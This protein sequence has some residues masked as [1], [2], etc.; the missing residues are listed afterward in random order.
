MSIISTKEV[1][2][3]VHSAIDD[4]RRGEIC[5]FFHRKANDMSYYNKEQVNKQAEM[6]HDLKQQGKVEILECNNKDD[7]F[8]KGKH[9]YILVVQHQGVEVG[10]DKTGFSWD[11]R[12]FLVD[13]FIY[14]FEDK[15]NR[16]TVYK[17]VMDIQDKPISLDDIVEKIGS[18]EVVEEKVAT[19]S[20]SQLKKEKARE[21]NKRRA[22]E[23]A[24]KIKRQEKEAKYL[25]QKRKEAE[26][27]RIAVCRAKRK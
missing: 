13:G 24:D 17:Y 25:E 21:A 19:K 6:W 12:T 16:D 8:I 26:R 27:K 15:F 4:K 22:Q 10:M 3:F 2:K 1:T 7:V 14:Y 18:I 9:F 5:M 20:K 11:D 23:K